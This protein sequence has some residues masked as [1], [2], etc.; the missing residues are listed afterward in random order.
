MAQTKSDKVLWEAEF[1]PKVRTY[2]L[3]SGAI[4]LAITVVGIL[5]LPFWFI[6]GNAVIGRY[7]K[8]MSCTLSERNL[9]F[10]KGMFVRVEKTIPLDKIT[11]LG[12]VQGPIMRH[13]DLQALSVETAGQSA[14]GAL[15]KLIGIVNTE[16][17]RAAVLKQRDKVSGSLTEGEPAKDA[18]PQS[19]APTSEALLTEIRDALHRIEHQLADRTQ[20]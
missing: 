1:N 2:W 4:V 16:D 14:Q 6:F 10:S 9:R 13:Y 11:D 5:L 7:L 19:T 3:L 15:L 20:N 12:L 17:F 18:L 8:Y